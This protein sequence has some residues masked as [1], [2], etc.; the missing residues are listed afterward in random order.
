M[1]G[2]EQM[3]A[4]QDLFFLWES[5]EWLRCVYAAVSEKTIEFFPYT[6]KGFQPNEQDEYFVLLRKRPSTLIMTR[7]A[8][9]VLLKQEYQ[10]LQNTK[11][12]MHQF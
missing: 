6:S 12:R 10:T 9:F 4:D 8:L 11:P 5:Y 2:I 3:I 7:Y 1:T